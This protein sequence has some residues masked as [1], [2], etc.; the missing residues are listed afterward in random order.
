M[1]IT[2]ATAGK[3]PHDMLTANP[4]GML[5]SERPIQGVRPPDPARGHVVQHA[6]HYRAPPPAAHYT[7][8]LISN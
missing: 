7:V 8:R 4:F 3:K 2:V 6:M 5:S 1:T